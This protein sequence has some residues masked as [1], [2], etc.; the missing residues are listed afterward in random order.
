MRNLGA[1]RSQ[2]LYPVRTLLEARR[3][4]AGSSDAPVV[5]DAS[6]L[7]GIEAA[8]TRRSASGRQVA[9]S[10]AVSLEQ[11]LYLYTRGAAAAAGEEGFKGSIAPGKLA[12]LAVLGD[13][14]RGVDGPGLADVDVD[15]TIVDGR[16]VHERG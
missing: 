8:M 9:A 14:I 7:L 13:D 4:V 11:A 6:P 1:G 15:L 12:D 10:E 16:V 3:V 5:P 2:R